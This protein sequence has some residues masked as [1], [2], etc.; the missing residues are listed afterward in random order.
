M[1]AGFN[2][3]VDIDVVLVT[4]VATPPGRFSGINY[5]VRSAKFVM[6]WSDALLEALASI[7]AYGVNSEES[8]PVEFGL[9]T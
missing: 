7:V 3:A 8:L 1:D 5:D 9:S 4:L 2:A 6:C